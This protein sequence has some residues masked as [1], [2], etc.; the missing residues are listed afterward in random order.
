MHDGSSV[1]LRDAILRHRGE[2]QDESKRFDRLG[3]QDQEALIEFLRS[4]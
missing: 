4:L 1:T 3:Q 2:A